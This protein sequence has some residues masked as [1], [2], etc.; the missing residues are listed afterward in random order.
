MLL[1]AGLCGVM[2]TMCSLMCCLENA[3]TVPINY[4]LLTAF[5]ACWSVVLACVAARYDSTTVSLAI[6]LCAGIVLAL[7][8]Y[9]MTTESDMEYCIGIVVVLAMGVM[10]LSFFSLFMFSFHRS[11]FVNYNPFYYV[12]ALIGIVLMGIYLIFDI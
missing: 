11:T 7:T 4:I 9:A 6:C 3:V 1:M 8:L 2:G 10:M 12:F 5:T